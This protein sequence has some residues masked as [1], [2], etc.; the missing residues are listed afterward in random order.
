M[1]VLFTKSDLNV[2]LMGPRVD[3]M[4]NGGGTESDQQSRALFA[5]N[6]N[7]NIGKETKNVNENGV[8][9]DFAPQTIPRSNNSRRP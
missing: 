9:N 7:L 1:N 3:S 6:A 8:L 5:T 2:F 4:G